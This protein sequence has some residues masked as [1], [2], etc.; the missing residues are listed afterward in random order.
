MNNF[1]DK[2][3]GEKLYHCVK[4]AITASLLFLKSKNEKEKIEQII[5]YDY[6]IGLNQQIWY[7]VTKTKPNYSFFIKKNLKKILK[8]HEVSN[9]LDFLL[10]NNI[11]KMIEIKITDKDRKIVEDSRAYRN[12]LNREIISVFLIKY[13]YITKNFNY[14][15][16][17]FN[18]LFEEV[19]EY[20]FTD[21]EDVII[22]VPLFNFELKGTKVLDL[23][24]FKIRRLNEW[25]LKVLIGCNIVGYISSQDVG[26]IST[27]WGLELR[28]KIPSKRKTENISPYIDRIITALRL[29]KSGILQYSPMLQ[30]PK[31]WNTMWTCSGTVPSAIL[32]PPYILDSQDETNLRVLWN[33]IKDLGIDKYKSIYMAVRRF[34]FSYDRDMAEDKLIDLMIAFESL[35]LLDGEGE[36]TYRLS[37]RCAHYIGQDKNKRKEAFENLKKAYGFRSRIVHGKSIKSKDL[38]KITSLTQ[39]TAKIEEYLRISI[40]LFLEN[41]QKKSDKEIIE[42]INNK[43]II[44]DLN[45]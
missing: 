38:E 18:N 9:C 6:E 22:I 17:V 23:G 13:V 45:V 44:G 33:Q 19:S 12:A 5:D 39:F 26:F 3:I 4:K 8:L 36:L 31:V 15:E 7:L 28:T 35:Y 21:G 2:E 32:T 42:E 29:L 40:R 1:N 16:A 20:I 24:D 37:L 43:I 30:Y 41:L 27:M 34:N 11:H 25:E 10:D 14:N